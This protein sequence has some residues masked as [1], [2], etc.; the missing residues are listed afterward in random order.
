MATTFFNFSTVLGQKSLVLQDQPQRRK[1][2]KDYLDIQLQGRKWRVSFLN[3][4]LKIGFPEQQKASGSAGCPL[5]S[6]GV[7]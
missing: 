3:P 4:F 1:G 7:A 5:A 2:A 6:H